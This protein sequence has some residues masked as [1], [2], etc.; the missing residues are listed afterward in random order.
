MDINVYEQV[1]IVARDEAYTYHAILMWICLAALAL[2]VAY[3]ACR[4]LGRLLAMAQDKI[5]KGKLL[6]VVASVVV[7]VSAVIYGGIG[8]GVGFVFPSESGIA[9]AG[10]FVNYSNNTI[11]A[12]WS[13]QPYV[14]GRKFK[15]F[16]T[17]KYGDNFES[18]GPYQLPDA[19]VEDCLAEYQLPI[20]E[21]EDWKAMTVTCYTQ[22][23]APPNVVTNGVYHLSGVTRAIGDETAVDPKYVTP[24]IVIMAN[25]ADGGE[26]TLTPTN[27]P[28]ASTTTVMALEAGEQEN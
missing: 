19:D 17:Y 13:Y 21:G 10:S 15:W 23:V 25:L 20:P 8:N 16:Y 6:A 24:G 14:R 5:R 26:V 4:G 3:Y 28:P 7:A 2:I 22:Y 11:T 18:K 9:D 1:A 12:V 27:P